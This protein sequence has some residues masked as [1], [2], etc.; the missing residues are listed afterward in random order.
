MTEGL[1]E[2]KR[3]ECWSAKRWVDQ[4]NE[5]TTN[6]IKHLID[7]NEKWPLSDN[8]YIPALRLRLKRKHYSKEGCIIFDNVLS[9]Y[10]I[11]DDN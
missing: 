4:I 10:T 1:V 9:T 7:G 6:N 8:Q 11:L 5:L 3:F 2:G